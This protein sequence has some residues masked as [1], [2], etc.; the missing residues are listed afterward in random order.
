MQYHIQTTPIWDA[1]SDQCDC[2]LCTLYKRTEDRLIKRYLDDAVMEP[3]ARVKVNKRGFCADHLKKLFVG[4][5]KLGLSLQ[6]HTRT[7]F[8]ID[9]LS[10]PNNAS[11]AKKLREKIL[12]SA[13]TCVIC[14]E[15]DEIMERYAYTIAEMFIYEPEFSKTFVQS[16]GFCLPHFA[17]LLKFVGRAGKMQKEYANALYKVQVESMRKSNDELDRFS[18]SFDYRSSDKQAQTGDALVHSI[19]KL[20]GN[21]LTKKQ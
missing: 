13:D 16:K 15:V 21:I 17:L 1:F 3:S 19:N 18:R 6:V 5:N 12:K 20:K 11:Q 8:I 2:P 10:S 14:D 4:G 9:E 7:D